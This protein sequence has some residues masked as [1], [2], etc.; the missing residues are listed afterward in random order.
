MCANKEVKY[1]SSFPNSLTRTCHMGDALL[2]PNHKETG[3]CN[4][5]MK[6]NGEKPEIVSEQQ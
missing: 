4:P 6:W 1:A 2:T 3:K 5:N